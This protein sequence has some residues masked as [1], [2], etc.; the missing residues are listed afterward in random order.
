MELS[1]AS[2]KKECWEHPDFA[3][4]IYDKHPDGAY[5]T[6]RFTTFHLPGLLDVKEGDKLEIG[7]NHIFLVLRMKLDI[8][9]KHQYTQK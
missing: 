4:N 3:I 2:K 5:K 8:Y 6:I 1:N 9:D 7:Y